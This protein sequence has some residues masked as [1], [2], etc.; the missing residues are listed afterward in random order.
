MVN[1][2][3]GAKHA[4]TLSKDGKTLNF[5]V[6]VKLDDFQNCDRALS[7]SDFA[8]QLEAML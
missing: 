7:A 4:C 5:N 1:M 3:V 2:K 8:K 6:D